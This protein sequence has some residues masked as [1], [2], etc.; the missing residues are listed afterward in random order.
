VAL[1]NAPGSLFR[2][3]DLALE[4][5]DDEVERGHRRGAGGGGVDDLAIVAER[6]LGH[7]GA[8]DGVRGMTDE[9]D[10]RLGRFMGDAIEPAQLS[11]DLTTEPV[12]QLDIAGLQVRLHVPMPPLGCNA[13]QYGSTSHLHT[14]PGALRTT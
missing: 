3:H 7:L 6:D 8:V 9:L 11:L 14:Q 1:P 12:V 10:V 4:L 5:V 13:S 2:P